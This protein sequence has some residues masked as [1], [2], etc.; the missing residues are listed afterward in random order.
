MFS[1]YFILR[2]QE[3]LVENQKYQAG[4]RTLCIILDAAL[5]YV[6]KYIISLNG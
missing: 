4:F 5:I 6:M 2:Q 1:T 3:N